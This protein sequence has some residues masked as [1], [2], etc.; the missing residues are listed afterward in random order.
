MKK[1]PVSLE[2]SAANSQLDALEVLCRSLAAILKKRPDSDLDDG[3][4]GFCDQLEGIEFD[5]LRHLVNNSSDTASSEVASNLEELRRGLDEKERKIQEFKNSLADAVVENR[6]LQHQHQ[7]FQERFNTLNTQLTQM[8]LHSKDISLKHSTASANLEIREKELEVANTELQELRA[9]SYYLKNLCADYEDQLNKQ[10]KELTEITSD[11][12]M[13]RQTGEKA[14]S[15]LE[16]IANSNKQLRQSLEALQQR[17]TELE[18]TINALQRE[19]NHLQTQL[20]RMLTGLNKTA[21]YQQPDTSSSDSSLLEPKTLV[22]YLPFCFPERLPPAIRFRREVQ[23]HLPVSMQRQ[24]LPTPKIFAQFSGFDSS[25]MA[26][27]VRTQSAR[28]KSPLKKPLAMQFHTAYHV[29]PKL[30]LQQHMQGRYDFGD[31]FTSDFAQTEE[32]SLLQKKSSRIVKLLASR[33]LKNS[34]IIE[35]SFNLFIDYLTHEIVS[36]NFN[37]DDKFTMVF[38]AMQTI[39]AEINKMKFTNI[40]AET[41]AFRHR[42]QLQSQGM[43]MAAPSFNYSFKRSNRLKSV[44]EMFGNTISSMVQKY[45]IAATPRNGSSDPEK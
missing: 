4:A 9:R 34:D 6:N 18:K 17:E 43:K 44:L 27:H 14:L 41:L 28:I 25:L 5:E 23:A 8:Q 19:K 33:N 7:A 16:H 20:S 37:S 38:E 42:F 36:R 29:R 24:P 31:V 13:L 3:L 40:F 15:D 39:S 32:L 10:A 21:V 12:V 35:N 26:V 1:K 45:D 11:N 30:P 2:V 22:P